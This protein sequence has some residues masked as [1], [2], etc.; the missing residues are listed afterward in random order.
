MLTAANYFDNQIHLPTELRTREM[1]LLPA[2]ERERLFW[3]AGVHDVEMLEALDVIRRQNLEGKLSTQEARRAIREAG[4]RLGYKPAPGTEGTIKDLMSLQRQNVFLDTNNALANGWKDWTKQQGA[5]KEFPAQRL[6]RGKDRKARRD[7]IL[8]WNDAR[9]ATQEAGASLATGLWHADVA[10]KGGPI[11]LLNH[12]IWIALSRF[13]LPYAPPD[14]LSGIIYVPASWSE[15]M[16]AGLMEPD[17]L[18]M[19]EPQVRGYNQDLQMTPAVREQRSRD[20]ISAHLQGFAEWRGATLIFTDPNGLRPIKATEVRDMLTKQLPAQFP[21]LQREALSQYL[22]QPESILRTPWSDKAADFARLLHRV[23]GEKLKEA[24]TG[25]LSLGPREGQELVNALQG[26]NMR[27]GVPL[28]LSS[29][30]LTAI[31]HGGVQVRV[32]GAS[33]IKDLGHTNSLGYQQH[34]KFIEAGTQLQY[35]GKDADGT[36]ILQEQGTRKVRGSVALISSKPSAAPVRTNS[37]AI[38]TPVSNSVNP[39][40][41]LKAAHQAALKDVLTEIDL[42]HGDGSLVTTNVH[43]VRHTDYEGAYHRVTTGRYSNPPGNTSL[44]PAPLAHRETDIYLNASTALPHI[45]AAHE[46]G[47]KIDREGFGSMGYESEGAI[48]PEMHTVVKAIAASA[49]R[50]QLDA[51]FTAG[52]LSL[53]M[54]DYLNRPREQFARAYAQYIAEESGHPAMNAELTALL[55]GKGYARAM[56]WQTSD[57]API[58]AAIT[59]LFQALNWRI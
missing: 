15:A 11:A 40:L 45:T 3:S 9:A 6:M 13:K 35:V 44:P 16:D 24:L 22:T 29:G 14:Y 57:F 8:R 4:K 7:W 49:A 33:N 27:P 51:F 30:P 52:Q 20:A 28:Q 32:I 2:S 47:H 10:E 43:T 55:S 54:F 23:E 59:N 5:L 58:R 38:S 31:N 53:S 39:L 26:A 46:L 56:Q 17:T 21:H 18:E 36:L 34:L 48:F 19:L 50:K 37:T 25:V 42:T 41:T 12:P 1:E